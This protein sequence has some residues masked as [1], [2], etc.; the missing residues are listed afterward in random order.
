MSFKRNLITGTATAMLALGL[1]GAAAP[2]A[3]AADQHQDR[4]WYNNNHTNWQGAND[5]RDNGDGWRYRNSRT[6]D[7][8]FRYAG[9]RPYYYAPP[10]VYYYVPAHVDPPTA[11]FRLTF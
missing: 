10:P 2:S 6:Y 4:W 8:S 11:T 3:R 1:L 9:G 5:W 7:G